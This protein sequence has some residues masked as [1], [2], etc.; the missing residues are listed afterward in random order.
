[1]ERFI[2]LCHGSEQVVEVHAFGIGKEHN[3]FGLGFY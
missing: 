2:T 1:M 3:D